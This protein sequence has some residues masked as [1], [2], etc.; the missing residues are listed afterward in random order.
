VGLDGTDPAPATGIDYFWAVLKINNGGYNG[1]TD[2]A[3]S[4]PSDFRTYSF[5]YRGYNGKIYNFVSYATD[6][7]GN[8]EPDKPNP[9]VIVH[10]DWSPPAVTLNA[11]PPYV[12][13]NFNLTW[14]GG[15]LPTGNDIYPSGIAY[16][17]IWFNVNNTSW[18]IW[19]DNIPPQTTTMFFDQA[20]NY[21]SY[22]FQVVAKDL[23][24]NQQPVLNA[25]TQ[26]FVDNVPPNATFNP[27]DKPLAQ[28]SFT[29]S[30]LGNDGPGCGVAS[31]DVQYRVG[32]GP[33]QAWQ[34]GT[35]ATS[36]QFQGQM[37]NTYGFRVRATDKAGN[38]GTFPETAQLNVSVI[39]PSSLRYKSYMPV[40]YY[41]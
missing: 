24:G 3:N 9:D 34:T 10:V 4:P 28:T 2:P 18:G 11:I 7:A 23:A 40:T 38:V 29:V 12:K 31:Y 36:A 15:D 37:G 16:Y 27:V 1:L 25:Q 41:P 6:M 26:T 22:Q 5:N 35:T 19:M 30:W 17:T 8:R 14:T 33:W 39:Q 32:L 20:S 21:T 13:G